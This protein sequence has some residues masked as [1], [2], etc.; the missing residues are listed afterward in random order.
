MARSAPRVSWSNGGGGARIQIIYFLAGFAAAAVLLLP[1]WGYYKQRRLAR[2]RAM[3]E[4]AKQAE[5]L[6][7][8]G[9]LAGG[10]AHEIKN[11]L[12][13]LQ[14]NLQ[15]LEEEWQNPQTPRESRLL[16]KI[17]V[18][19]NETKR[20]EEALNDFLR[21]AKGER[22]QFGECDVNAV[23][24]EVASFVEPEATLG[25][26]RIRRSLDPAAPRCPADANLLR[27]ALLNLMI[28]ARQAMPK[29]GELMIAT[30]DEQDGVTVEITDTGD[31]IA[32]EHMGKIFQAYYSTK[33]AGSGLGLATTKRIIE[34]HDGT[35][36]VHSEVGKGTRFTIRLPKKQDG[37]RV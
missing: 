29:G 7:Y 15:L 19:R 33:K 4:R 5:R 12:S 37:D 10:L 14:L 36:R 8:V 9:T 6:A 35:I 18:L 3:E 28:N 17:E 20:L 11:P 23:V 31:G 25:N 30:R 16:K 32:P 26:I 21:F 34:E 13:T 22:P 2:L 24:D 27:Q 1:L